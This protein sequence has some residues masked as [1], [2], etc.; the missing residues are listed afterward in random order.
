M[1]I[2][3]SIA[4]PIRDPREVA[5][6]ARGYL[7]GVVEVNRILIRRRHVPPIYESG[8]V[9]KGE[10]WAGKKPVIVAAKGCWM[11]L[12]GLDEFADCLTTY[13]RGCGDC[14]D[15]VAWRVAELKEQ[16]VE[17]GVKIYW[18]DHKRNGRNVRLFHAECRLPDGG[19]EDVARNLGM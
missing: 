13:K 11:K 15:L 6:I 17:A 16:G 18:R 2:L 3:V 7:M 4:S 5:T 8:V 10:P 12:P 9:F 1:H 19:V 14:D